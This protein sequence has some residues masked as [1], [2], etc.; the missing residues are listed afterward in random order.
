MRVTINDVLMCE[1]T[2][3]A[4]KESAKS[5]TIA[6]QLHVGKPMTLQLKDLK[7]TRVP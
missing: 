4:S 7:L 3:E 1:V 6:F 5:G 2:D